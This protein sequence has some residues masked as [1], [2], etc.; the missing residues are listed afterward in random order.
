[1]TRYRKRVAKRVRRTKRALKGK[2]SFVSVLVALSALASFV[3]AGWAIYSWVDLECS[4]E[5]DVL[6]KKTLAPKTLSDDLDFKFIIAC[7][8]FAPSVLAFLVWFYKSI[9]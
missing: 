6:C 1:M 9:R 8:V 5:K 4:F 2:L 7:V 3:L